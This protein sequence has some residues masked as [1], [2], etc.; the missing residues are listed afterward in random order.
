MDEDQVEVQEEQHEGQE[1]Q[2][3]EEEHEQEHSS[4]KK[5]RTTF[6]SE[7][8][9]IHADIFLYVPQSR[10]MV[11]SSSLV[12]IPTSLSTIDRELCLSLPL[13]VSPRLA[14]SSHA[15][16]SKIIRQLFRVTNTLSQF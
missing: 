3:G 11:C 14:S 2:Q 9:P 7:L 1:E 13:L 8:S 12:S 5:Y 16:R 6:K 15:I 4:S 10:I